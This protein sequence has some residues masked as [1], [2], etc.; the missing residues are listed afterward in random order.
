MEGQ[1]EKTT[2]HLI[3]TLDDLVVEFASNFSLGMRAVVAAAETYVTALRKYPAKAKDEFARRFPSIRPD[4]WRIIEDV[5]C[6]RLPPQAT[7][8][9]PGAVAKLREAKLPRKLFDKVAETKVS[10][11]NP[12]TG[13][14]TDVPFTHLT[15]MQADII[16]NPVSH[17]LRSAEQ[18]KRYVRKAVA[19]AVEDRPRVEMRRW[20]VVDG[21]VLIKRMTT[22][23]PDDIR[24]ISKE[25]GLVQ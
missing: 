9:A 3:I 5:G 13:S 16:L 15:E 11:Y 18:Q 19:V 17:D 22:L 25:M 2:E 21:G 20:V 24:A 8:M 14:F 1:V 7:M 4:T 6:G 12:S 23:T 10:V